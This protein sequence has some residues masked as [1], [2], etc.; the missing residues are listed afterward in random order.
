MQYIIYIIIAF[1]LSAICGFLAI[2]TVLNYCKKKN[3]YDAPNARKIHKNNIPRLGGI[4]FMPS[5]ALAFLCVIAL[6]NGTTIDNQVTFSLW[7]CFFFISLTLIYII[8]IVDDLMGLSAKPKFFVQIIAASLIPLSGLYINNL[9]GLFGFYELP[10]WLGI[11]IT[12]FV[13]VFVSNAINLIDGI[14][15]LSAGLSL[16][17]LGGFL[18]CF[19]SEGLWLYGLLIASLMGVLVAFFFFNVFGDEEKGQKIFMGDS[20]SLTLGFILGFLLVKFS[21]DNPNVMPFRRDSLMLSC[22]MLVVPVFD[23]CRI[24][25]VRLIHHQPIFNADK[26]HIH[27]KLMRTGLNQHQ[28][29]CVI[30]LLAIIYAITNVILSYWLD[31]SIIIIVNIIVWL[32]FHQIVNIIIKKQ[33]SDAFQLDK[34]GNN[35]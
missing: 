6:H 15:G 9:Y 28:T 24:I 35:N 20:G 17:S 21:M 3:L 19:T 12:V 1:V 30:L 25:I 31:F 4:C 18:Y 29:L 23:V 32:V 10:Y 7:S 27:H 14:D 33:G 5:M 8:G 26:N 2:P 13:I 16:L 11:S 22:T 34:D